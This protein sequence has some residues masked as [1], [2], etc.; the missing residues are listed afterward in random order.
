MDTCDQNALDER[1]PFI[2]RKTVNKYNQVNTFQT[3]SMGESRTAGQ[4]SKC[5][6]RRSPHDGAFWKTRAGGV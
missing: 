5:R 3:E 2:E 4:Y 6:G 1:T